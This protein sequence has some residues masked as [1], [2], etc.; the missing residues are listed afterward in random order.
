M[1][2]PSS[3][4]Q[5]KYHLRWSRGVDV[6]IDV[7]VDLIAVSQSKRLMVLSC[8]G[9]AS[10]VK[11]LRAALASEFDEPLTI[12][13]KQGTAG[14]WADKS[15][16][17]SYAVRLGRDLIHAIF[18]SRVQGLILANSDE[19]LWRELKDERYTTPL[20]RSWMPYVREE[21]VRRE[22]LEKCVCKRCDVWLLAATSADLDD[23]VVDGV[24]SGTLKIEACA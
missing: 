10:Q 19:A 23:I 14:I 18:V 9:P 12:E 22:L 13:F 16:Y 3:T 6:R 7:D 17:T 21:L 15:R 8:V 5:L 2:E 1:Q 4:R 20:L 24:K 11:A